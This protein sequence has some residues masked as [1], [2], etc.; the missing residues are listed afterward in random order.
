MSRKHKKL[1]TQ[2]KQE[3]KIKSSKKSTNIANNL[4]GYGWNRFIG[5]SNDQIAA[6][7][8]TY[9]KNTTLSGLNR[10][11]LL[12]LIKH[13]SLANIYRLALTCRSMYF[14]LSDWVLSNKASIGKC[15]KVCTNFGI[16]NVSKSKRAIL[17]KVVGYANNRIEYSWN[18][19]RILPD[20]QKAA[21]MK[22]YAEQ[23]TLRGLR[24]DMLLL[25][26]KHL[27][28]EDIY[29]LASTCR[30]MYF[31][32]MS[33]WVLCNKASTGN[34]IKVCT[35]FGI[36][37]LVKT[38]TMDYLDFIGKRTNYRWGFDVWKKRKNGYRLSYELI[39]I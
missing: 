35:N 4:I 3:K 39:K 23:A 32:M 25:L 1:A 12:V 29:H 34:Y 22:T 30:S 14:L 15:I 11:L 38:L 37:N 9:A 2:E 7:I 19:F 5:L 36:H 8:K 6:A 21:T 28:L 31:F 24:K 16:H 13:L 27:S 10:D 26:V 18:K 17:T 33:D 20:N